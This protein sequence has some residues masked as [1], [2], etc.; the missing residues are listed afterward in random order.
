[1]S[2]ENFWKLLKPLLNSQ[3]LENSQ[4]LMKTLKNLQNLLKMC[5]N[6]IKC[7]QNTQKNTAWPTNRLTKQPTHRVACKQL[8]IGISAN[9]GRVSLVKKCLLAGFQ[10]LR[11]TSQALRLAF[12]LV[13][14]PSGWPARLWLASRPFGCPPRPSGWLPYPQAFIPGPLAGFPG[15]PAGLPGLLAGL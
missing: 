6:V 1:M 7:A 2:N 5:Q 12:Q 3:T 11:L 8:K 14:R 10:T 13:S 9:N 4:K 15:L